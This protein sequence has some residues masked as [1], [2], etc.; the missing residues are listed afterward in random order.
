MYHP[1][2]VHANVSSRSDEE[3]VLVGWKMKEQLYDIQDSRE[4]E[5]L[6]TQ[7]QAVIAKRNFDRL[8]P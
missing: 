3:G 4:Q 6:Q 5:N 2:A 1:E 8:Q 7:I